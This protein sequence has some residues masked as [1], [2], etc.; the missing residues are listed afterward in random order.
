[1][2]PNLKQVRWL[3]RR[4]PGGVEFIDV[5]PRAYCVA[6]PAP[7]CAVFVTPPMDYRKHLV[8]PKDWKYNE[9]VTIDFHGDDSV[10][11]VQIGD[12]RTLVFASFMGGHTTDWVSAGKEVMPLVKF[13]YV[14]PK[15]LKSLKKHRSQA[16]GMLVS[17]PR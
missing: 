9:A 17:P 14:P 3:R 5:I 7:S 12:W 11:S 15:A 10:G 8:N 4:I 2:K 16:P 1:M 13:L 6:K